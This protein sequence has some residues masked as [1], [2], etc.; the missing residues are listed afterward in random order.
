MEE[1]KIIEDDD[2]NQEKLLINLLHKND[3]NKQDQDKIDKLQ[4]NKDKKDRINGSREILNENSQKKL[5]HASPGRVNR[6]EKKEPLFGDDEEVSTD[7][8][9]Q[10]QE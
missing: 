6:S 5:E 9:I 1:S 4:V 8:I 10:S 7:S 2:Q 3:D